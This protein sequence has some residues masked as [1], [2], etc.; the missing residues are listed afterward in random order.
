LWVVSSS[1]ARSLPARSLQ[2]TESQAR[3]AP[4]LPEA[5]P[6]SER[7]PEPRSPLAVAAALLQELPPSA[8]Q[9]DASPAASFQ[10]SLWPHRQGCGPSTSRSSASLRLHAAPTRRR[11]LRAPSKYGCAHA[12]PLRSRSS[13]NAS[14]SQLRQLL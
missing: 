2:A 12:R 1:L 5:S 13:S 3:L 10:E 8:A 9:P 4:R 7:P 6:Q 11:S 14:S